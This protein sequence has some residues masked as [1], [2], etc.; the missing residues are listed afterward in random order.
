M[1]LHE[2]VAWGL[3]ATSVSEHILPQRQMGRSSDLRFLT[4][5]MTEVFLHFTVGTLL[6]E[7]ELHL[8]TRLLRFM[9]SH[10]G[11]SWWTTLPSKVQNGAASRHKWSAAQL[12]K[13]RVF[14]YP[15]VAWF[16]MGDI[17][18]I[19]DTLSP[20]D[21]R[22]C[23]DAD[24]RRQREFRRK[25]YRIKSYRDYYVAHP[26][27]SATSSAAI[28]RLCTAV[29][30]IPEILRPSE[31]GAAL[32]LIQQVRALPTSDREAVHQATLKYLSPDPKRLFTRMKRMQIPGAPPFDR[33]TNSTKSEVRWRCEVMRCC[34]SHDATGRLFFGL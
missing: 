15:D 18:T 3:H 24:T 14:R 30:A 16:T 10:R 28:R 19:L 6:E 20:I 27:P 7:I 32:R 26:K 12:G 17:A 2:S 22:T 25:F 33:G 5:A 34:A 31:W 11:P 1:H 21:W 4:G 13:K 9:L 8:K 29:Q 23:L